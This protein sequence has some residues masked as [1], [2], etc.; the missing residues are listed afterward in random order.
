MLKERENGERKIRDR[1][2]ERKIKTKCVRER[3]K[4]GERYAGVREGKRGGERKE[5]GRFE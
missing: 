1:G 3:K 5:R 4:K 2:R